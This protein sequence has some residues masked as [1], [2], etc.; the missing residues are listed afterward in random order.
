MLIFLTVV[1]KHEKLFVTAN[2][3]ENGRNKEKNV[4]GKKRKGMALLEFRNKRKERQKRPKSSIQLSAGLA[5]ALHKK[6]P[7]VLLERK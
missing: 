7:S 4:Y 1:Y 2:I 3:V 6:N 5:I